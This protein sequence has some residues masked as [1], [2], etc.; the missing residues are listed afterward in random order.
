MQGVLAVTR[1]HVLRFA[2]GL[3]AAGWWSIG[4]AG[5]G[6]APIPLIAHHATYKLS[7]LKSTGSKAPEAVEGLLSYDFSGSA[8]EGYAMTL[9]QMTALQPQEGETH[10]SDM[11]TASFEG[12]DARDYRFTVAVT[13]GSADGGTVDGKAHRTADGIVS[14]DLDKPKAAKVDLPPGVLFP[15]E[16]LKSIIGTA[17]AGGKLV[18]AAVFD[19]SETG[20]KV[21]NTLTVIGAAATAPPAENAAQLEALQNVQRWPVTISY[22]DAA[23]A[24]QTPDYVLSF[25]LYQN[26][27]SRSLKLDYGDFVL[28]GELTDLKI[29]PDTACAQ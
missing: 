5:A 4:P 18:S 2:L 22:F 19:G 23:K 28:A 6:Q 10:V 7:L 8:C 13:G 24:D 17:L 14:V 26:G 21:F 29:M 12:G 11:Q 25:D 20:T 9:R 16:H 3:L 15:T 27:I 1:I